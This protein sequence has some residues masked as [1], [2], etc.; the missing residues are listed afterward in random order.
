MKIALDCRSVFPGRGGIGRYAETLARSLARADSAHE[1]VLLTTE[2]QG[3][4]IVRSDKVVET[5]FRTGMIDPVWEQLHLPVVLRQ[6][7]VDLYHNPC[8]SLP[9]ASDRVRLV[10]TVHDVVFRARPDLVEPRLRDYLARWTEVALKV[11]QRIITVSRYSKEQIVK[12]YTPDP[13]KVHVVYNGIDQR[14]KPL[15]KT[16]CRKIREKYRLPKDFV[17]YMG[18]IEPKKNLDVLL[19]A[20]RILKQKSTDYV[21]VIAGPKGSL[22]YD[23]HEGL[24]KRNLES[25]VVLLGYVEDRDVVGLLSAARVFVYPSL[26]EGFGFPPLEA[27]ACGTPTVVSDATSLPEVV[28]DGALVAPA[29]DPGALA[30]AIASA[31][32][33]KDLQ[34]QLVKKGKKRARSFT[35]EQCAERTLAVY[36]EAVDGKDRDAKSEE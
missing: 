31:F 11:G 2:R 14:F 36:R 10:S 17:L 7:E 33:D 6:Q 22:Q 12:L 25:A 26:Y 1:Y 4:P 16:E 3:E 29:Q 34:S 5:S 21:L 30:G 9:V 35:W 19:D 32:V 15:P 28:G 13:D 18:A 23:L 20:Q 8:F 27:M 24:R